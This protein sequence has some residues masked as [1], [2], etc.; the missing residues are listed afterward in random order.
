MKLAG[1]DTSWKSSPAEQIA[2]EVPVIITWNSRY[3][4]TVG[5]VLPRKSA[6]V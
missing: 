6:E 5:E 2:I 4:N 3:G 1:Y